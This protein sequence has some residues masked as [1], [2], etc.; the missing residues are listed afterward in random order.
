M[1]QNHGKQSQEISKMIIVYFA[2]HSKVKGDPCQGPGCLPLRWGLSRALVGVLSTTDYYFVTAGRASESFFVEEGICP[3]P[4]IIKMF[5]LRW[6]LAF[7]S[8][9]ELVATSSIETSN[10]GACKREFFR[11]RGDI[12]PALTLTSLPLRW[13]RSRALV[14][15]LKH[16]SFFLTARRA[17]E[18]SFVEDGIS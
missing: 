17:S 11:R 12:S 9:G 4:S 7:A 18:S 6:G 1:R 14:D 10:R 13:G 15:V 2:V 3:L 8:L 16:D 5:A